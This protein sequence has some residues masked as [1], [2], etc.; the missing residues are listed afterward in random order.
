VFFRQRGAQPAFRTAMR[1]LAARWAEA[2]GV[3]RLRLALFETPD[4]EAERKAGYPI[5]THPPERQ[6]QAWIDLTVSDASALRGLLHAAVAACIHTVHVYPVPVVYT[7]VCRGKP[8]L[9]GLRGW[10]A[11]DAI[12]ALGADNQRQ[13]ALLE[14]MYGSVA[15]GGVEC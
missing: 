9:V 7:S 13:A 5:K 10:P 11:F 3:E 2:A 6:Y 4:M 14:W 1:I 15:A 12:E 8:T